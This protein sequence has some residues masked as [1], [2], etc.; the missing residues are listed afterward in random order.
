[1]SGVITNPIISLN[2]VNLENLSNRQAFITF[3]SRV[4]IKSMSFSI[5]FEARG[6]VEDER[7]WN[8]YA[9]IGHPQPTPENPFSESIWNVFGS[10]PKPVIQ[11]PTQ[12][13]TST[14]STTPTE[15]FEIPYDKYSNV[16]ITHGV[17]EPNDFVYVWL[18]YTLEAGTDITWSDTSATV[19][20]EYE[21][22]KFHSVRETIAKYPFLD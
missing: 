21:D 4:R 15:T 22:T 8:L 14:L 7:T 20:V 6:D 18:E 11:I 1:M 10:N 19:F 16:E 9:L 12:S 3:P 5:N 2:F 13:F 17:I